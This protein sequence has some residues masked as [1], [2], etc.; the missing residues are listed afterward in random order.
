MRK[1]NE[2]LHQTAMEVLSIGAGEVGVSCWRSGETVCGN[3]HQGLLLGPWYVHG[4]WG[5]S[6][7][8][9]EASVKI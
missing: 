5:P 3:A 9:G 7:R 8:P 4:F 1:P 2:A 6:A